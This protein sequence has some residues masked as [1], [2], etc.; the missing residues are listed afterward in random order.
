MSMDQNRFSSV[1]EN[2]LIKVASAC[3]TAPYLYNNTPAIIPVV[4]LCCS[5]HNDPT[6]S[7]GKDAGQ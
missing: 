2:V 1:A 3:P 6:L 5:R 7:P 4:T